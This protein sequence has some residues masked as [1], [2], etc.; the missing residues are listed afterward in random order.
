MSVAGHSHCKIDRFQGA[1][2]PSSDL[3]DYG[4]GDIGNYRV[5]DVSSVIKLFDRTLNVSGGHP[6]R[7]QD[8]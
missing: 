8:Q 2:F 6:S 4:I 7:I 5:R 1:I 3:F